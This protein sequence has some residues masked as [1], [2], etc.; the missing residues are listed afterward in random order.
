M[1]DG[2]KRRIDQVNVGDKVRTHDPKTGAEKDRPVTALHLNRDRELTYLYVDADGIFARIDTTQNHLFWSESRSKWVEAGNLKA[3]EHL[4]TD[5]GEVVSIAKV[6]NFHGDAE[7]RDLTVASTH[8]YYV[9]ADQS[10]L[11][12]HNQDCEKEAPASYDRVS[13]ELADKKVT[14]GQVVD[15][16]GNKIG[17]PVSSGRDGSHRAIQDLLQ[18]S[19]VPMPRNAPHP[20][21]DHVEAK[22][23]LAMR[24]R[25]ISHAN[26]VINNGRGVCGGPFSCQ[27]AVP[28]ILPAGSRMT[29]WYPTPGGLR[30]FTLTGKG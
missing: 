15:D 18:G 3:G 17:G 26:V 5:A 7:M 20:A 24:R 23:A 30:S 28:A 14:T 25:G 2:T 13:Q 11:L 29:V 22:I 4:R 12:V 1:A 21:A 16:A 27:S 6:E 10:P 8:T 9:V 19:G